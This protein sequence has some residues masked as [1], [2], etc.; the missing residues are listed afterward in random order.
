MQK[1]TLRVEEKVK[2]K[3]TGNLIY[4]SLASTSVERDGSPTANEQGQL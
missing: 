4:D 3:P 1:R 2:L